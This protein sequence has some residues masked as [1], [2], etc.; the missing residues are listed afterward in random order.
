MASRI[1]RRCCSVFAIEGLPRFVGFS[2]N[3]TRSFYNDSTIFS[4]NATSNSNY[5]FNARLYRPRMRR[6]MKHIIVVRSTKKPEMTQR[7][8]Y[9]DE[10]LR[11]A[12]SSSGLSLQGLADLRTIEVFDRL[13][14]PGKCP[15]RSQKT[16]SHRTCRSTRARIDHE[17]KCRDGSKKRFRNYSTTL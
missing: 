17:Q 1:S 12:L 6:T 2:C 9:R 5:F 15:A 11:L 16:A 8:E 14:E 13:R 7:K 3:G 10:W 4:T